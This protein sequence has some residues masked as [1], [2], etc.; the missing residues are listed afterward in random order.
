MPESVVAS[1]KEFKVESVRSGELSTRVVRV[2]WKDAVT[3]RREEDELTLLPNGEKAAKQLGCA[4]LY[5][6]FTRH[7]VKLQ[8]CR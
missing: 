1:G 3:G 6:G 4:G 8:G 7:R 2:S 5:S